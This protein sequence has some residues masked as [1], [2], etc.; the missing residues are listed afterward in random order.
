M[1]LLVEICGVNEHK[2]R[3]NHEHL[4]TAKMGFLSRFLSHSKK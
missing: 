4:P 1:K 2:P 3:T